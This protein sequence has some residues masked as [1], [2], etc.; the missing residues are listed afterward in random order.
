MRPALLKYRAPVLS[1]KILARLHTL[2]ALEN[3]YA[4]NI[5]RYYFF[6]GD[7]FFLKSDRNN[8]LYNMIFFFLPNNTSK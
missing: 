6:F 3:T 7:Y 2:P 8:E 1:A 5:S 4:R